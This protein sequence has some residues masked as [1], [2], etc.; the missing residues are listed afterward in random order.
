MINNPNDPIQKGIIIEDI[1]DEEA[2]RNNF[3]P[4]NDIRI[5]IE[6]SSSESSDPDLLEFD[7]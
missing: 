3:A 4:I 7:Y 5:T 2:F 6:M 1:I